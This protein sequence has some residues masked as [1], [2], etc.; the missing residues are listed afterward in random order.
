M[1]Q[2][3]NFLM[4]VFCILSALKYLF[5]CATGCLWNCRG[6]IALEDWMH[7]ALSRSPPARCDSEVLLTVQNVFFFLFVVLWEVYGD[8]LFEVVKSNGDGVSRMCFSQVGN[9][10]IENACERVGIGCIGGDSDSAAGWSSVKTCPATR[11]C[12]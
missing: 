10:D 6:G 4:T 1:A 7:G 8:E 3:D 9:C 12:Y 2:L 11:S 5:L